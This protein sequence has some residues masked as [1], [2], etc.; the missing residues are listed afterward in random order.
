MTAAPQ[1]SPPRP[2][3][4]V[5]A[6]VLAVAVAAPVVW[7]AARPRAVDPLADELAA[8]RAAL[9]PEDAVSRLARLTAREPTH[10]GAARAYADALDLA[11]LRV[12]ARA[13][14]ARVLELAQQRGDLP[15]AAAARARL[16]G[17]LDTR[18]DP[19]AALMNAGLEALH[20]RRDA[21]GAVPLF[22]QVLAHQPQHYGA[23][24]QLAVA[25]DQLGQPEEAR[26]IWADVLRLAT[27]A[28]DR[29]TAAAA[30]ARLARAP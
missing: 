8:A 21:A 13:Q 3:S 4:L 7:W 23:T 19:D 15:V 10:L 6:A 2:R 30:T 12:E 25:L 9:L 14:W 28:A 22:R 16:T 27:A 11:G 26:R 5:P 20:G 17:P 1:P 29:E 24:Y 18:V